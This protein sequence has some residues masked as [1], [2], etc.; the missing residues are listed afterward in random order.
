MA[1]TIRLDKLIESGHTTGL[2][3]EAKDEVLGGFSITMYWT[4]DWT[5]DVFIDFGG[6]DREGHV[7]HIPKYLKPGDKV[8]VRKRDEYN[9]EFVL[10]E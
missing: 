1:G 4:H 2:I 6:E 9:Y 8:F 5:T 10:T 7:I 3:L